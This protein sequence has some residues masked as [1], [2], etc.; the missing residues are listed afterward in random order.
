LP[1]TAT[2]ELYGL[3]LT[4]GAGG[5]ARPPRVN[6]EKVKV[7]GALKGG[8]EGAAA[9]TVIAALQMTARHR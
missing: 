2:I 3:R 8:H 5:A 1:K 6:Y 9:N 4:I 7:P